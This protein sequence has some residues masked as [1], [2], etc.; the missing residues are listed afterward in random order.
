M[1]VTILVLLLGFF[2][3]VSTATAQHCDIAQTGVAVF[4]ESNTIPISDIAP[5]EYANFKFSIGN[6]GSDLGCSI[7]ANS[8]T[9]TFNFPTLPGGIKPYI[10]NGAASFVSGYF[11]WVYNAATEIL[12]GR[13]TTAIP[14]GLGDI[15]VLVKVKGIAG[16]VGMSDLRLIPGTGVTDNDAN[17]YSVAQ[18]IVLQ[19]SVPIKL[20]FFVARPDKCDAILNWKTATESNF[21]HFEVEYSADGFTYIK[22]GVIN[23]RNMSTGASYGFTYNQ[24]SG[25][26]YYRLKMV[27]NDGTFK[28]SEIVLVTTKC[29]GNGK[30]LAYPNP[31]N[32]D[33]KLV[34][35]ISG[36]EGNLTGQLYTDVAHKLSDYELING[37]NT[38]SVI[39]LPAGVYMLRIKHDGKEVT[40]FKI[41]V[42]R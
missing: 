14:N 1:K 25:P 38:I 37:P 9:A 2:L 28:Y 40:S 35:N 12:E 7:P 5:G 6:F 32:Y 23:G 41:I 20:S 27:D 36:Y 13:N 30:I 3:N 42:T 11:T 8:V 15:E 19:G 4:N 10:Y 16:G 18:L 29:K 24:L 22:V 33:Q 31:L 21:N 17:N 34:V 26:G 39:D